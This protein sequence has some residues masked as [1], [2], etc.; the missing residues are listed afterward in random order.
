MTELQGLKFGSSH[1]LGHWLIQQP[2]GRDSSGS[3]RK[4]VAKVVVATSNE[5]FGFALAVDVSRLLDFARVCLLVSLIFTSC[6]VPL[7]VPVL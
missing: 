2:Y 6:N 5:G 4:D 1:Y 7:T 3:R